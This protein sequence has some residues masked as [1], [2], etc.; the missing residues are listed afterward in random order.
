VCEP[1]F[2]VPT[3]VGKTCFGCE[4]PIL[5]GQRGIAMSAAD[6]V[7]YSFDL[8]VNKHVHRV[9]VQHLNCHVESVLGPEWEA[10]VRELT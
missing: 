8:S 3:P 10:L 4:R 9:V 2:H 1:E 7:P 6:E 5:A